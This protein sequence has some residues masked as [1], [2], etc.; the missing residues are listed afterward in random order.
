MSDTC[1]GKCSK[2]GHALPSPLPPRYHISPREEHPWD[3]VCRQIALAQVFPAWQPTEIDVRVHAVSKFAAA[4][5][6]PSSRPSL[7]ASLLAASDLCNSAFSACTVLL[8]PLTI[9][10]SPKNAV[11]SGSPIPRKPRIGCQRRCERISSSR[12]SCVQMCMHRRDSSGH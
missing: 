11:K 9:L 2:Q 5:H 7:P 8:L 4:A 12:N 10:T 6:A 3:S 1:T